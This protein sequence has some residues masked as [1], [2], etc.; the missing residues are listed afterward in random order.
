MNIQRVIRAKNKYFEN[1]HTQIPQKG[2]I[3]PS[4]PNNQMHN[5]FQTR[6]F[7]G[8]RYIIYSTVVVKGLSSSVLKHTVTR[9]RTLHQQLFSFSTLKIP[10]CLLVSTVSTEMSAINLIV[11]PLKVIFFPWLLQDFLF[12]LSFQGSGVADLL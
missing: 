11:T 8:S 1:T 6:Y 9:Y 5:L 3:L 7:P 12:S 10:Q 2:K 4:I